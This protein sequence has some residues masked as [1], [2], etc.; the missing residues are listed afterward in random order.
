MKLRLA[1]LLWGICLVTI[2]G[3]EARGEAYPT[4]SVRIIVPA[5]AGSALDV[6]A[7]KVADKLSQALGQA[8]IV[9]NKPGANGII[10]TDLAAKAKP[11]GYTLLM[12][13]TST[14]TINPSLYPSLPYRPL[15]D[16]APITLAVRGS[17]IVLVNASLP[18]KTLAEFIDLAKAK[19]GQLHYGSPG[20]G[21]IQHLAGKLLE[22]N[23]GIDM[24]HVPYKNQP[25]ILSD[26]ISGR[27]EAMIEFGAVAVPLIKAGKL[28]ALAIAGSARKPDLPE[29][30]T[31]AQAGAGGFEVMG[32]T[33]YLAPAGT[34]AEI[35]AK[36]N[37]EIRAAILAADYSNWVASLGS[38]VVGGPPQAFAQIIRADLATWNARI[39]ESGVR[40]E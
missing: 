36:L 30:P 2:A 4:R 1:A 16:F 12:G 35:I 34:P 20:N 22:R 14:L 26:L 23:A 21:S 5:A 6:N 38:E 8:V 9:D 3:G 27:I 31:A 37:R 39:R 7:R 33:G 17:P 29:V 13:S 40:I 32:W 15:N 10:G 18:V 24:V 19:P 11:D 25:E 28:R